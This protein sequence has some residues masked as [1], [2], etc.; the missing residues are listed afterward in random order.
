LRKNYEKINK[1]KRNIAIEATRKL[2]LN[3]KRCLK[4]VLGE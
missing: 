4:T 2:T 3:D 1:N